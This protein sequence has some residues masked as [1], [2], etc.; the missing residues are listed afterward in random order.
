MCNWKPAFI[1]RGQ[2]DPCTNG[3]VYA[4]RDEAIQSAGQRFMVW[5]MPED[6]TAVE[7]DEP[8]NRVWITGQGSVSFP[9]NPGEQPHRAP[10]QVQL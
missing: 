7:S 8:V 6:F 1:F 9:I 2:A 3:E 4:T 10:T 5:T